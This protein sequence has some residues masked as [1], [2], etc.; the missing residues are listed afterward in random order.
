M[1][2]FVVVG[3][4]GVLLVLI[5][6]I[7]GDILDGMLPDVGFG[8]SGGVFSTEV[9]GAFLGAFGLA[10]ALVFDA[11]G[12]TPAASAAAVG[13]G[14]V[15]GV[16][17]FFFSRALVRMPTDPTPR[18]RDLVGSIGTVVTRI[19]ASGLGEISVV[20]HGQRMK[21]SA[22]SDTALSAG[23]SV[24]VVDVVSPTSVVVT[25]SGF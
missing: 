10:G 6:L 5:A 14:A 8:D 11:S 12:S 16:A 3:A 18:T 25:E 9:V 22:R 24:V 19:P 17:T 2:V 23:T 4:V 20:F 21:L 15:A 1:T 7:F 13:A